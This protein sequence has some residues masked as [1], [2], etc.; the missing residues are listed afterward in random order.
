MLPVKVI[1]FDIME[2]DDVIAVL[3]DKLETNYNSN[4]ITLT[5]NIFKYW[6][7]RTIWSTLASCSSS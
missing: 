5:G 3:A 6:I 7:R 1:S 2:A 4:D